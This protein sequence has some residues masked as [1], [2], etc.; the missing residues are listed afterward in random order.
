MTTPTL[1]FT[2]VAGTLYTSAGILGLSRAGFDHLTSPTGPMV[3]MFRV[4]GLLSLAHLVAGVACLG[5]LVWAGSAPRTVTMLAAAA[6]GVLGLL[7]IAM[8][9]A[10]GN[11]LALNVADTIAHLLTASVAIGVLIAEDAFTT[12]SAPSLET[13]M[14]R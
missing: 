13:E 5:A 1:R 9:G 7:G 10:H 8:V 14:H 2:A 3:A 11:V 12:P 6:F 4:N